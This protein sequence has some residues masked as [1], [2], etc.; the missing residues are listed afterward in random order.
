M[1]QPLA[2]DPL[3]PGP[4]VTNPLAPL[5][6][7]LLRLFNVA[8][9]ALGLLLIGAALWMGQSFR[10]GGDTPPPPVPPSPEPQPAWQA[11]A[12][13]ADA[14]LAA[15]AALEAALPP[16]AAAAAADG[17]GMAAHDPEVASFPW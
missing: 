9:A 8:L 16:G 14:A 15:A 11:A 10:R 5:L 13:A 3:P 2:P 1:Y 4:R 6:R 7:L 17:G 12:L